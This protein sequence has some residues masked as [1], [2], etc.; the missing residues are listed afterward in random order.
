MVIFGHFCYLFGG[1]TGGAD[2]G[3]FWSYDIINNKWKLI[4]ENS[5]DHNGPSPR[6]CHKMTLDT[7]NAKIYTLGRYVDRHVFDRKNLNLFDLMKK[8]IN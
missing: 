2:L 6:S 4:Y 5:E 3:D 7:K 1:W 8:E